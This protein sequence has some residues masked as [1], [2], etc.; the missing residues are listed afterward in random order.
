MRSTNPTAIILAAVSLAWLA[1][2]SASAQCIMTNPS[3]ELGSA[4][5]QIFGGWNEF[6]DVGMV[7]T[8]V[9]GHRA[10]RVRGPDSDGWGISGFWQPFD[11]EAGDVWEITGHVQ[12]PGT[13]PLTGESVAFV[14]VEW[15][16]GGGALLGEETHP[17]A[18]AST[19]TDRYEAF[20]LETG[21]APVEA[22]AVHLIL[23]VLQ[24]P[25]TPAPDAHY[26]QITF[27]S[28][29]PPTIDELQWVDFP[30]GRTVDF[31]SRSWRVKG[32]GIFGPGI[33]Y[34]G[35]TFNDVW[36]DDADRL[37]LVVRNQGTTWICS[38]VVLEEALGY[39]DYVVTTEGRLDLVDPQTVLGIFLWSY[40]P[41][42]DES[43]TWWN[44]FNEVD[45]EYS[46][47]GDPGASIA[48]FVAQPYW[49]PGNVERFDV[50]FADDE[51]MSHAMRW[52]PDR[53]EYRVWRGGPD[54]EDATTLVHA[55]TYEGPHVSRPE[56]PR[57]HLNFWKL[58]GTPAGDQEVVFRDFRFVPA[59]PVAVADG[60]PPATMPDA[61]GGRLLATAPNPFNPSTIVSFEL[62]RDDVVALAVF[63]LGGRQVR[64]L[65]E[66]RLAAGQHRAVWDGRDDRGRLM[67]SGVYLVQLRGRDYAESRRVAL[68]K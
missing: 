28:T 37:H 22:A 34:F 11:T 41:C 26:D 27:F 17:V 48:Q 15:R 59:G 63:D 33:N 24:E 30:S 5:D 10:A 60:Q 18:D 31:A 23:A 62:R 39:G 44:A 66:G 8:A 43:Y 12:H 42:W 16:D 1:T 52:L 46:R 7:T 35:H 13:A 14:H 50:T 57:L 47:W 36:V 68:I 54:D 64:T 65:V 61:P 51:V 19:P 3:F 55:W 9:H 67:A 4:S 56:Q 45:I 20:V 21:P 25:G 2:A 6:G 38:E 49:Y 40:G 29:T 32:P 58:E 53:I